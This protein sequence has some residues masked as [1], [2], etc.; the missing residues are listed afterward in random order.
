MRKFMKFVTSVIIG[1]AAATCA[2]YIMDNMITIPYGKDY[3]A[4]V[5]MAIAMSIGTAVSTIINNHKRGE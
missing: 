4:Y 1:T 5:M 3:L 2:V